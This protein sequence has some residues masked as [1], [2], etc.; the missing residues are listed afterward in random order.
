M[1]IAV[2]GG[3]FNPP[4]LGHL[5]VARQVVKLYGYDEV[6]LMPCF[7]QAEGKA[8]APASQRLEMVELMLSAESR[9]PRIKASDFEVRSRKKNYTADTVLAL[10]KRFPEHEFSWVFGSEL[11]RA[12]PH[13][14]K[15]HVLRNLLPLV[16]YPRPGFRK[17]SEKF[18]A[19]LG[20]SNLTFLPFN[21]P[22]SRV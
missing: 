1:K 22:K 17:P 18:V 19:G 20:A 7:R 16:I 3:S 2:L 11:V 10:Q 15:W 21:L 9:D 6:W 13:W 14:G 12:F 4:H 5:L 8:L